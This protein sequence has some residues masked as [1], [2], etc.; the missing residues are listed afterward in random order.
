MCLD[1]EELD[2][3]A[4]KHKVFA[5][6]R[7]LWSKYHLNDLHAGTK[8]QEQALAEAYDKQNTKSFLKSFEE[9]CEY[10]KSIGL[11]EVEYQGK[12]Y[13]Y[14]SGWIFSPIPQNELDKINLILDESKSIE[15]L[16]KAFADEKGI[17]SFSEPHLHAL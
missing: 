9:K 17:L 1:A 6:I 10:L 3:I 14:G 8:E 2:E 15:E 5:V 11:Y 4:T 13:R 7:K 16:D 12:P